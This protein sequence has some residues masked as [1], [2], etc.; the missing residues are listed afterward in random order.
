MP[1]KNLVIFTLLIFIAAMGVSRAFTPE[2]YVKEKRTFDRIFDE[3]M[4]NYVTEQKG[5][6][7]YE[8]AYRGMLGTLDPYSQ[9]FNQTESVSFNAE[10]EG[11][12]GGI[13]VEIS[14]REGILTVVTPIRGTP[15]Y[16][17]GVL[18]GDIILKIDGKST[19]RITLDEAVKQMRGKVGTQ[20]TLTIRHLGA[21]ADN[22]VTLTRAV[23]KP[24]SVEW[25]MI[26]SANGIALVR[27]SSFTAKVMEEMAGVVKD[28]QTQNARALIL[29]L[30][31][32]PGGLLD[33]AVEMADLFVG[34]GVIVSVKG[35]NPAKNIVFRAHKGGP[36]EQ[37]PVVVVV[38]EG[39]AS[40][41][42]IVAA[43]LKDH[44][45]AMLVG[46]RT[47]GKGSVQNVI[48]LSDGESLKLTTAKYYRPSDK[49]IEDRHGIFPD[50]YV[51]LTRDMLIALRNQ[52]REDK[53]RGA[54]KLGG[55]LEEDEKAPP[56]AKAPAADKAPEGEETKDGAAAERRGRVVDYQLKA[57]LNV[58]RW[59]LAAK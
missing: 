25:E 1:R 26:D 28:V 5:E 48:P 14:L 59:Q 42:E 8:G 2:R 13:G 4:A 20:L 49:P 11:E 22:T 53:M 38:D 54:W 17:A 33:K 56:A 23:I 55:Q 50:I 31:G 36:F 52:E 37:M 27:V 45:R 46:T 10:T 18:A 51:P 15:A 58:L 47:Y 40:A 24:A 7:L 19:E 6:K 3:I 43:A 34:E 29:D 21:P 35:R 41:S 44:H 32:N 12:F 16:E 30:R 39:S 9:Y 57:A